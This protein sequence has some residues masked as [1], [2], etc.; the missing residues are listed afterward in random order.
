M[1]EAQIKTLYI[2]TMCNAIAQ[3]ADGADLQTKLRAMEQSCRTML[4]ELSSDRLFEAV[5]GTERQ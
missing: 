2:K 4:T 3:L 5:M 1:T